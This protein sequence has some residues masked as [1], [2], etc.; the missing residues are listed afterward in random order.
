MKAQFLLDGHAGS[1]SLTFLD[2]TVRIAH[3]E[4]CARRAEGAGRVESIAIGEEEN[5]EA[6]SQISITLSADLSAAILTIIF[7]CF[8]GLLGLWIAHR[9]LS[10]SRGSRAGPDDE[11]DLVAN[12]ERTS[13][14]SNQPPPPPPSQPPATAADDGFKVHYVVPA[15]PEDAPREEDGGGFK[16]IYLSTP[17]SGLQRVQ[18]NPSSA[19][20]S[21][22]SSKS[23]PATSCSSRDKGARATA[24]AAAAT[25]STISETVPE[26]LSAVAAARSLG[27]VPKKKKSLASSPSSGS[28][29]SSSSGSTTPSR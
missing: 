10:G 1:D 20:S 18:R 21:L 5:R 27:A 3:F 25:V 8:V 14:S 4:D 17:N 29:A 13:K 11:Q 6:A 28:S 7:L 22:T 23:S 19:S 12:M 16:E 2:E 15:R 9:S 26:E 24:T